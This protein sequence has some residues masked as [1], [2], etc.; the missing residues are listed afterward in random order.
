MSGQI[1]TLR[2]K[3]ENLKNYYIV[4][5]QNYGLKIHMKTLVITIC[6]I[7]AM[8]LSA[9]CTATGASAAQSNVEKSITWVTSN[10]SEISGKITFNPDGTGTARISRSDY[11]FKYYYIGNAE[12]SLQSTQ[13]NRQWTLR[14][15][16]GEVTTDLALG[17]TFKRGVWDA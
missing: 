10:Q 14:V 12:Y 16:N 1:P 5:P 4:P 11:T 13:D 15:S 8:I 7:A 3:P 6:L 2:A 9:G 17:V